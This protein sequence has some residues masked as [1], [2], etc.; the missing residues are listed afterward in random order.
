MKKYILLITV[1]VI[2]IALIIWKACGV[3]GNEIIYQLIAYYIFPIPAAFLSAL[4]LR[5]NKV[6]II[7]LLLIAVCQLLLPYLLFN[8][9]APVNVLFAAAAGAAGIIVSILAVPKKQSTE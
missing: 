1:C 9:V 4:R 3:T 8:A 2:Y 6:N 7:T 5:K